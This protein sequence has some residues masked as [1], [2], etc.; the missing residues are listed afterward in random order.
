MHTTKWLLAGGGTACLR[1]CLRG[2][3]ADASRLESF[4]DRLLELDLFPSNA[5]RF[6]PME[7]CLDHRTIVQPDLGDSLHFPPFPSPVLPHETT[8]AA[9]ATPGSNRFECANFSYDLKLHAGS[10]VARSVPR[11]C[12]ASGARTAP[13][14]RYPSQGTLYETSFSFSLSLTKTTM[15]P[16][17]I[18]RSSCLCLL[19]SPFSLRA[20]ML[21]PTADTLLGDY[22]GVP[23]RSPHPA[24]IGAL[25]RRPP[26]R[27]PGVTAPAAGAA[28]LD[29]GGCGSRRPTGASG[30]C[31]RA[32]G[33][34]GERRS[35]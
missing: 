19:K 3:G 8:A 21:R 18:A 14:G 15:S 34:G 10:N 17:A 29:R 30:S 4:A 35:S 26:A 20:L 12:P 7:L 27:N 33:P 28:T 1:S 11:F 5:M 24:N 6:I 32:S 9:N 22:A 25:T 23:V 2:S 16:M 31:S 13:E